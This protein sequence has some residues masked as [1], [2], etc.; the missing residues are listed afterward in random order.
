MEAI[1]NPKTSNITGLPV[2][3]THGI[4]HRKKITWK[5]EVVS[6]LEI[7]RNDQRHFVPGAFLKSSVLFPPNIISSKDL[8]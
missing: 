6:E 8:K 2:L 7:M 1:P 5:S 3:E 4:P